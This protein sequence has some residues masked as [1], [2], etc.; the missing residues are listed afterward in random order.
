MPRQYG[1]KRISK[2]FVF[3][4]SRFKTDFTTWHG[5]LGAR[6]WSALTA[7][8]NHMRLSVAGPLWHQ[9]DT[10]DDF[11]FNASVTTMKK[12][13]LLP[14]TIIALTLSGCIA[15]TSYIDLYGSPA[16]PA[17]YQRTSMASG[18]LISNNRPSVHA[19]MVKPVSGD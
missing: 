10:L 7:V 2:P 8:W 9:F 15:R 4:R 19:S 14:C 12:H 18:R 16:P 3:R 17:D 1:R 6:S 5:F 13:H 11:L